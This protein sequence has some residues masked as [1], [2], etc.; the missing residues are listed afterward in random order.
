MP[1]VRIDVIEGRSDKELT[2]L[3]DTI[4]EVLIETFAAPELDR[5]Q[6]IHEH[7]KGL[8]KALDTGLGY[9][10]TDQLVLLQITHQGRNRQQ[11]EKMYAAM[12]QKLEKIGISP[13]DLIIS[14][15]ENNKEDWS[16]GLGR[17]QFL[18]GEL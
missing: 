2:L 12:S 8:I 5:Y 15:I 4:Q 6:V 11:K 10:R 1:L 14:L 17:A 3:A 13:T 16:F 9:K 18:T 7:R